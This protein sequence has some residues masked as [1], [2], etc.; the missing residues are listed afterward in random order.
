MASDTVHTAEIL[1]NDLPTKSVTFAPV[2]ATIVR[3]I[4]DVQIMVSMQNLLLY[5]EA[6]PGTSSARTQRDHHLWP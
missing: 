2:R 1:L 3:E 6:N 4:Q 5:G